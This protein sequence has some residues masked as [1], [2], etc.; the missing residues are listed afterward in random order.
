MRALAVTKILGFSAMPYESEN[1]IC[2]VHFLDLMR[3]C[4]TSHNV[5]RTPEAVK[6]CNCSVKGGIKGYIEIGVAHERREYIKSY[7]KD[8][9]LFDKRSFVDLI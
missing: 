8:N 1:N 9:G 4:A 7:G 2:A 3:L 5:R 6:G